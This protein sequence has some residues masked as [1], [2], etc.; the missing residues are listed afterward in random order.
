[1]LWPAAVDPAAA[2][3]A[4]GDGEREPVLTEKVQKASFESAEGYL[5]VSLDDPAELSRTFGRRAPSQDA[6]DGIGDEPVAD[7][8]LVA[9]SREVRLWQVGGDIDEGA[10][11]ARHRDPAPDRDVLG[12]EEAEPGVP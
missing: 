2:G 8:G 1:V 4:V 5:H 11:H 7:A 9:G 3:G 6:D 12:I 10:R